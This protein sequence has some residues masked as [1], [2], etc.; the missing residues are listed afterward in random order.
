MKKSNINTCLLFL[1]FLFS[2]TANSMDSPSS[3][4]TANPQS[5]E[6]TAKE[7]ASQVDSDDD[8]DEEEEEEEEEV[9][10]KPHQVSATASTHRRPETPTEHESDQQ[11]IVPFNNM[12]GVAAAGSGGILLMKSFQ[13][14][15][16]LHIRFKNMLIPRM[17]QS[18]K[19]INERHKSRT[20]GQTMALLADR[21]QEEMILAVQ[22]DSL[23][24]QTVEN[25]FQG[26]PLQVF[27]VI[28]E[29]LHQTTNQ[30]IQ[31]LQSQNIV[32]DSLQTLSSFLPTYI[33]NSMSPSVEGGSVQTFDLQQLMAST[34]SSG[35]AEA[36]PTITAQHLPTFSQDVITALNSAPSQWLIFW[37]N[38]SGDAVTVNFASIS[39]EPPEQ[40]VI[41]L[42][43][44]AQI[45][46]QHPMY[47]NPHGIQV[48]NAF[49]LQLSPLENGLSG[50]LTFFAGMSETSEL[51]LLQLSFSEEA[52]TDMQSKIVS[53]QPPLNKQ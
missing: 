6:L 42:I 18:E 45:T 13:V 47:S 28:M 41:P 4:D 14:P 17:F 37:L 8:D 11:Q 23:F 9:K 22:Q 16:E 1:L 15:W 29:L 26:K 12:A 20:L 35:T 31:N 33:S 2:V 38:H 10:S 49:N 25:I 27:S 21:N 39:V 7:K 40:D 36:N 46:V 30:L 43:P 3:R 52:H 34:E 48:S 51:G 5:T 32:I 44:T 50:L 24:Q 53:W 19:S